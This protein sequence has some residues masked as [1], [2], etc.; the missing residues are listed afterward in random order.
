[1][2]HDIRGRVCRTE[3]CDNEADDDTDGLCQSCADRIEEARA[4][5]WER[6]WEGGSRGR[7][8]R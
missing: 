5:M 4:R 6:H 2:S 8:G 1:M 7:N 3:T